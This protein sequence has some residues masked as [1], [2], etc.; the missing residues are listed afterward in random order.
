MVDGDVPALAVLNDAAVPAVNELGEDGLRGH[1]PAC[2]L[3]LVA[4]SPDGEPLGML[5]A[6]AP[7]ADYASE[8]YRWFE[9]NEPGSLYVDRI[10][11]VPE[12]QGLGIGRAMHAAALQRAQDLEL[13][14]V[15]CE[16]NVEPPNPGSLLFHTR[17]GFSVVGELSTKGGTVRVALMAREVSPGPF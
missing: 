3:A 15:T 12:A 9:Q 14:Q 17:L 6:L 8:N 10:L 2:E 13:S 4:E 5:L 11:V 16:V 7:G 1:L